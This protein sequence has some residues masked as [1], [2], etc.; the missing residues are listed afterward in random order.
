[1][2]QTVNDAYAEKRQKALEFLGKKWVLH[3]Q[4]TP[5]ERHSLIGY[6]T[7]KFHS[8]NKGTEK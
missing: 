1:M 7:G 2:T 8:F 5:D 3:P 4:Y 6:T